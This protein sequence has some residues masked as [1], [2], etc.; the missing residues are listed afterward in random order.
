MIRHLGIG[1]IL[2]ALIAFGCKSKLDSEEIIIDYSDADPEF[3]WLDDFESSLANFWKLQ[4]MTEDRLTIATE[5]GNTLNN[6]LQVKLDT[7]DYANG[8]RR[9]EMVITQKDSL[10]YLSEYS[11]RFKFQKDFFTP[12]AKAGWY[13]IHQ[14]HDVPA[15]GY[16]WKSNKHKTRPPVALSVNFKPEIGY[17]LVFKSGLDTGNINEGIRLTYKGNLEPDIWYTFS[18]QIFWSVYKTDGYVLPKI[19]G[20]SMSDDRSDGKVFG[21]N[22]Y[23]VRGN[24]IKFGL[25]RSGSQKNNRTIYFDDFKM[26]SRR[27]GYYPKKRTK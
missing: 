4:Q 16:N 9:S 20:E 6:V 23:N 26:T 10:G 19:N 27:I 7:L 14:W 2:L 13:I 8:G 11:F 5:P 3:I 21:R 25:Y 1:F 12:E 18:N 24:Y 15:V 17:S 22:M